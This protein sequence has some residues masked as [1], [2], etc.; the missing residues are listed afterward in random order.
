MMIV[1]FLADMYALWVFHRH[2][3]DILGTGTDPTTMVDRAGFQHVG[4]LKRK[5]WSTEQ[6]WT[7]W[8]LLLRDRETDGTIRWQRVRKGHWAWMHERLRVEECILYCRM[9]GFL[10]NPIHTIA[11]AQAIGAA[12]DDEVWCTY[13]LSTLTFDSK[14]VT[15]WPFISEYVYSLLSSVCCST[16]RVMFTNHV[17]H[18]SNVSDVTKIE[19]R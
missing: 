16:Q 13:V 7:R 3:R 14:V 8:A 18:P 11:I 5:R 15:G 19:V 4:E 12:V 10:P 1:Y 17:Q 6:S 9:I 2:Q